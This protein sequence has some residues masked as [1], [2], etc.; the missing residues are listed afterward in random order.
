[1][2]QNILHD[3]NLQLLNQ[4]DFAN[5]PKNPLDYINKVGSGLTLPEAQ[6]LARSTALSPVQQESMS[7]HHRL[8]HLSFCHIFRLASLGI[9]PKRL[10]ECRAKPP[11]CVACQFGQAHRR[12]CRVKGKKIGSIRRPEQTMHGDVVSVDQ[13]LSAQ[14]GLILQMW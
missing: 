14:P 8:Y 3:R 10:T 12:P 6:A 4:P 1:M 7:W 11:M 5:I 2:V 13:I 9:L